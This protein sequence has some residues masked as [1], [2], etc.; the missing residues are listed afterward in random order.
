MHSE[1]HF[2]VETADANRYRPGDLVYAIPGHVCP[3]VALHRSAFVAAQGRIV[4]EW[5]IAARDRT[6]TV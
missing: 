1:E 3:T 4:A 5:R 6:L 2:V